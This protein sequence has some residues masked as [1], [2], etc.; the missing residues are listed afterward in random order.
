MHSQKTSMEYRE[1]LETSKKFNYFDKQY[2]LLKTKISEFICSFAVTDKRT[3]FY[4][5]FVRII[6]IMLIS[7][8]NIPKYLFS[9]LFI[10]YCLAKY[11][12]ENLDVKI[13][14]K[15]ILLF[16]ITILFMTEGIMYFV[17]NEFV[18]N[19]LI[20]ITHIFSIYIRDYISTNIE[21]FLKNFYIINNDLIDKYVLICEKMPILI[22]KQ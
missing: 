3:Q 22:L 2:K 4:N 17:E 20:A 14:N 19:V 21:L 5:I 10:L 18:A 1:Q 12:Q 7:W 13:A 9:T 11:M 6:V 8:L 16:M 15:S